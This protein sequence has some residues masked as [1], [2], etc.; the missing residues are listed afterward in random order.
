[1][2]IHLG[3][4]L[5]DASRDLPGRR[6]ENTHGGHRPKAMPSGRPYSVLLPAGF[7]MPP[8]LPGARC[9]LTA[10]FHPCPRRPESRGVG[11]LLSVA[12]SLGLPPPGVTRH[13]VSVEPG[14]SSPGAETPKAAIRPSGEAEH[15]SKWGDRKGAPDRFVNPGS[16]TPGCARFPWRGRG[17]CRRLRPNL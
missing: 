14:L 13:R 6:R 8:P 10:P 17:A 3:R 1:M 9:A 2:A 16:C 4:P 11:G 15:S 7:T 5:P 12:L